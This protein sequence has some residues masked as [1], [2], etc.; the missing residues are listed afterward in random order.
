MTFSERHTSTDDDT[1]LIIPVL[2]SIDINKLQVSVIEE[3][4]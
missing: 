1:L 3:K 2:Y 4:K